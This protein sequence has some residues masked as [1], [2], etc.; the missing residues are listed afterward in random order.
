MSDIQFIITREGRQIFSTYEPYDAAYEY[1][2][3]TANGLY[4]EDLTA[5]LE[6]GTTFACGAYV[7][8][9]IER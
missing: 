2:R 3:I 5:D 4:P 8:A 9:R 6:H 7:L 1:C